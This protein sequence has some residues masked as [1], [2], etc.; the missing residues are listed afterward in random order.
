MVVM[1]FGGS[2]VATAA[3]FARVV[4]IVKAERRPRVV[5]VSALA[6]VT[7]ALL[8]LAAHAAARNAAAALRAV[9]ALREGHASLAGIVR[10]EAERRAVL[11]HLDAGWRDVETL[12]GASSLLKACPP[13]ACDAIVARGELASSRLAAAILKDAGVPAEWVDARHAV[14]TDS[15]HQ[16]A[17]PLAAASTARLARTVRPLV[18]R[19]AVPV[20]GGFVGST[21]DGVTT[22][23]GRGGSD[24]S[25]S[26]VGAC[27]G[28][29][30]IQIWTDVDGMLT[31][32]PRLF[33][34]A[35]A[36]DRLSFDEA[37]ALAHFG[38]KVLHPSTLQP[39]VL[40]G[41]PVR[42]L[43]SRHPAG[44]GTVV[45]AGPV[46]RSAP[47][48]GIACLDGLCVFE[49]P[50]PG[51]A[52]RPA[53]IADIY[54]ACARAGAAVHLTA[55]TDAGVSVAVDDGPAGDR[56]AAQFDSGR[57][58]ARRRGL[59][60]VAVVGDGLAAGRTD[61]W[62]IWAAF[63]GIPAHLLSST[64]GAVHVACVVD[65]ADLTLAVETLHE[66]LFERRP[67]CGSRDSASPR[68]AVSLRT[69]DGVQREARA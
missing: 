8:K 25:A 33:S 5:V 46:R 3:A 7:D 2:S 1:K 18:D 36:V 48:A 52:D 16:Q 53:A 26:L 29:S 65:E 62:R 32:D 38:A 56:V 30:E 37:S 4:S 20:L 51:G 31:A 66:R 40:A 21:A 15:R 23:L 63:D 69:P 28:A 14:V 59:A 44:R 9:R 54:A 64:T 39:A 11:G 19:G 49:A 55:V 17:S 34:R 60:L 13:P 45:A 47:A 67:S 27:L 50:L 6:G 10:D 41:I 68:G 42:I 61:R 43:N 22:T 35:R 58:I 57:R 24:Y 12:V